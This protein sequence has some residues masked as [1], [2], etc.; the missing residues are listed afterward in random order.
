MYARF[1]LKFVS[2][3]EKKKK[4]NVLSTH[5]ETFGFVR[6]YKLFHFGSN[7]LQIRFRKMLF[8]R[9][10]VC[11]CVFRRKKFQLWPPPLKGILIRMAGEQY[12][13]KLK[14][15]ARE[16]E[17]STGLGRPVKVFTRFEP[18][19]LNRAGRNVRELLLVVYLEERN[20]LPRFY[21]TSIPSRS[22]IIVSPNPML[23][24]AHPTSV[25]SCLVLLNRVESCLEEKNQRSSSSSEF[26][27]E[28]N[29]IDSNLGSMTPV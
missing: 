22:I 6:S 23:Q 14:F 9:V 2:K 19:C 3:R 1:L 27:D 8:P 11:V 15:L 10:P 12:Q 16:H 7:S 17:G 29:R 5:F 4:R 24:L 13:T 20:H 25:H 28:E 18:T 21:L 26:F